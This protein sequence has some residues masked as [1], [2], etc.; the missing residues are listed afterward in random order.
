MTAAGAMVIGAMTVAAGTAY[1]EPAAPGP[2][3]IDY[4]TR[5]VD[6]TIVTTLK[7]GTF[8]LVDTP[9]LASDGQQVLE[10]RDRAGDVALRMPLNF[11]VA[12]V[13]VPVRSAVRDEGRVLEL[14]PDQPAEVDQV[15]PL[16]AV[17]PIA[18][19]VENDRAIN[20]FATKLALSGGIGTAIGTVL[21]VA[22]GV[23]LGIP[24][25]GAIGC[26]VDVATGCLPGLIIGAVAGGIVGALG[27][28]IIGAAIGGGPTV[29]TAG[30]EMLNT[31]QAPPGTTPWADLSQSPNNP[32]QPA[33]APQ[34]APAA[35]QPS[36]PLVAPN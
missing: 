3:Y 1:G 14:T 10:L 5:V 31:L 2:E 13:P 20:D 21:G 35:P 28:G 17:R 32:V 4:A 18:S 25:G 19:P 12:G 15:H 8:A 24:I 36:A 9:D 23:V 27:V 34:P 11:R 6:R 16:T 22:V 29:S 7:G 30:V 26:A 33:P